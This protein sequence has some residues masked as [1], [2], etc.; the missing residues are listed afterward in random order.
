MQSIIIASILHLLDILTGTAA[1]LKT[2][3]VHSAKLREGIYK[4]LGF[5]V[6]YLLAWLID[7]YGSEIGFT[8]SVHILPIVVA[9]ISVTEIV[10]IIENI[11]KINP[12]LMPD[13]L[14]ELFHVEEI[15][16]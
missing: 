7:S 2:H 6:C 10:S 16:K 4:K 13:K 1:A 3:N 8:I 14:K 9:Y 15:T 5:Y 12:D 11:C